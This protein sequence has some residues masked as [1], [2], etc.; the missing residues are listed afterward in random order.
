MN[1]DM[2]STNQLVREVLG[3]QYL[4]LRVDRFQLEED[5]LTGN[6]TVQCELHKRPT[7]KKMEIKGMGVGFVD[8]VYHALQRALSESYPSLNSIQFS[9]FRVEAILDTRRERAGSD[10]VGRVVLSLEN[11][12]GR[13]FDFSHASRSITGSTMIVTLMGVE[14]F[15]NTERAFVTLQRALEDARKR[16]R[17]DLVE[18][19]QIQISAIV[20]NT[21]YSELIERMRTEAGQKS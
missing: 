8:A 16:N 21:S 10:A 18:R 7:G 4:D 3:D 17:S 15:V 19:Y 14:Y 6:C 13:Q 20:E 9:G 1:V 5:V 2:E 12:R 11:S